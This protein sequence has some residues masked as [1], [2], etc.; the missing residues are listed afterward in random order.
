MVSSLALGLLSVR[1]QN[2]LNLERSYRN[3][4]TVSLEQ[5]LKQEG[6]RV[7]HENPVLRSR[8]HFLNTD[9]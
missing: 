5:N 8:S 7:Y 3:E 2:E 4:D 9:T 1:M 6:S